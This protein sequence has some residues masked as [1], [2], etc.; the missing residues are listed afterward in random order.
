MAFANS[1]AALHSY[2]DLQ[3]LTC[4]C[5]VGG[6]AGKDLR[7]ACDIWSNQVARPSQASNLGGA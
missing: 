3:C 7:T 1:L 4:D 2:I 6:A 5:Y